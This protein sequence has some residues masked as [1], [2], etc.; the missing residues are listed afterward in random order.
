MIKH[1][2][3]TSLLCLINRRYTNVGKLEGVDF[4]LRMPAI[5]LLSQKTVEMS[6]DFLVTLSFNRKMTT[7]NTQFT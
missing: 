5:L 6:T 4:D 3:M 7:K 1:K 2:L